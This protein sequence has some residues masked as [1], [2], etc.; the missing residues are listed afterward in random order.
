MNLRVMCKS[1]VIALMV[2]VM[3]TYP[4]NWDW[5]KIDTGR[6][7]LIFKKQPK[8]T[9][10]FLWGVGTSSYQIEGPQNKNELLEIEKKDAKGNI[11]KTKIEPKNQ[12]HIWEGKEIERDG[13]K[14]MPVPHRSGD[15]CGS[16]N[17]Y[18]KDFQKL[19]ELKFNAY[20]FSIAWEKVEPVEGKWNEK[21]LDRYEDM[22]KKLVAKGIQPIVTLYHYTHPDWFEKKKGFEDSNNIKYFVRFCSKVFDRLNKYV[23][24]WFTINTFSGYAF[25]AYSEGFKPPFKKD[26]QQA[27]DVMKNLLDA[28]VAVY[29]ALKAKDQNAQIGIYKNMLPMDPW[30]LWDRIAC[31]FANQLMNESIYNYFLKGRF[32]VWMPGRAKINYVNKK[33]IGAFDAIGVNYYSGA[34]MHNFRPRPRPNLIKTADALYT[35]Y[36]EGLC[37]SL[38]NVWNNFA[39]KFKNPKPIYITETGIAPKKEEH[40][41]LFFERHIYAL[42]K[43]IEEGVPLKGYI[44]WSLMDNFEWQHGFDKKKFGVCETNFETQE[45]TVRKN[46]PYLLDVVK[47]FSRKINDKPQP[48]QRA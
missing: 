41:N 33:A 39:K 34:Y 32:K 38:K 26:M 9:K 24:L 19:D 22:C 28:H 6:Q 46:I 12:W 8:K 25:P 2:L 7:K 15:A 36:P 16:W 29:H 43:A 23:H 31:Y 3:K 21:A 20:R 5:K 30:N 37:R 42:S 48:D 18:E 14:W 44:V 4:K 27:V 45:R 1:V 35:I 40:R 11:F 10:G 13:E 47:A 17:L